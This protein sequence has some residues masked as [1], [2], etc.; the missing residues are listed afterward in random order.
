MLFLSI[1]DGLSDIGIVNKG[2]WKPTS[3]LKSGRKASHE[4]K[5]FELDRRKRSSLSSSVLTRSL[6]NDGRR[7]KTQ[8]Q[9]KLEDQRVTAEMELS[10]KGCIESCAGFKLLFVPGYELECS[11]QYYED[12]IATDQT[13][14]TQR[15]LSDASQDKFINRFFA[16][17]KLEDDTS[18]NE[19]RRKTFEN[20]FCVS[21][22]NG[23]YKERRLMSDRRSQ[24][25][26]LSTQSMS[27]LADRATTIKTRPSPMPSG[28][29]SKVKAM[30]KGLSYA[31]DMFCSASGAAKSLMSECNE[32]GFGCDRTS[33]EDTDSLPSNDASAKGGASQGKRLDRNARRRCSKDGG[34]ADL[35]PSKFYDIKEIATTYAPPCEEK[36][37]EGIKTRNR[38][39][40]P[41]KS[42]FSQRRNSLTSKPSGRRPVTAVVRKRRASTQRRPNTANVDTRSHIKELEG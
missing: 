15:R 9:D 36:M 35:M 40:A 4:D 34:P 32:L 27:T 28:R 5:N 21:K 30:A 33:S 11:E 37:K 24:T 18:C 19:D 23:A 16:L 42:Y 39:S 22:Y 20:L 14:G 25:G 10:A 41:G 7:T 31:E 6:E 13:S 26:G 38:N 2:Y 17:S 12:P 1:T 29:R 3:C 8:V